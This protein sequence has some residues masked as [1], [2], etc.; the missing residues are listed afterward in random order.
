[1]NFLLLLLLSINFF[2]HLKM[3]AN[4]SIKNIT[5]AEKTYLQLYSKE[6]PTKPPKSMI[7]CSYNDNPQP[8]IIRNEINAKLQEII[9]KATAQKTTIGFCIVDLPKI[10]PEHPE[11]VQAVKMETRTVLDTYAIKY[12]ECNEVRNIG[13]DDQLD[14]LNNIIFFFPYATNNLPKES[15]AAKIVEH[16]YK[17][18]Y[19]DLLTEMSNKQYNHFTWKIFLLISITGVGGYFLW[20]YF[21][22]NQ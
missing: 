10:T 20:K 1:M 18:T 9:K 16:Y 13:I 4:N 11:A 14:S 3:A 17:N 7:I 22:Y 19:N 15:E 2:S 5:G 8:D 6:I 21:L 12:V